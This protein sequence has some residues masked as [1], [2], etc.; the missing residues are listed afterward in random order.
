MPLYEI[1]EAGLVPHKGTTFRE[2]ELYERADLQRL[3]RDDIEA[4]GDDLRVRAEE[5]GQWEDAR[6]RIDRLALDKSGHLVVIELKR[7][8]EGGYMELQ[9][10]RYA[11]M[12]SSMGF[13]EV[14]AAYA[15]HLAKQGPAE[16]VDANAELLEWLDLIEGDADVPVISKNVRII[17][18]SADFG[19]EITTTVLWLN[20]VQGMD[21]RCV[22]LVPYR[23]DRR[24]LLDIQQVIPLP[25]AADYQVRLRRKDQQRERAHT[26]GRDRTQ[27][28]VVVDGQALPAKPKR[29][30]VR[31]MVQ[32]LVNRGV[33][34][35][36]SE[37]YSALFAFALLRGSQKARRL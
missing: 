6:R 31:A 28:H 3:L 11:A 33:L 29:H 4:I 26:D 8:E 23:I 35:S 34:Q 9:A 16:E 13:E 14:V 21:V 20:D 30:A 27:Y 37:R 10:L 25:E 5:F 36:G 18:V 22:R 24:T 7:T 32:E 15:D 12:V 19:R 1:S 2:L 17:L